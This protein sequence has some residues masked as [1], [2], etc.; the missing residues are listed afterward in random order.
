[1]DF[2]PL[3]QDQIEDLAARP[4]ISK[5]GSGCICSLCAEKKLATQ[6]LECQRKL[7][8]A[9]REIPEVAGPVDQRIRSL[10]KMYSDGCIDRDQAGRKV[11]KALLD[12]MCEAASTLDSVKAATSDPTVS[13]WIRETR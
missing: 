11:V 2:T 9:A 3:T 5:H 12:R 7:G 13:R 10:R 4:L 6:L 8:D 1:M